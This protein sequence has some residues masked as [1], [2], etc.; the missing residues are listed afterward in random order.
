MISAMRFE[1]FPLGG[2]GGNSVFC[3]KMKNDY[4]FALDPETSFLKKKSK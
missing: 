1:I 4:I 2:G 3:Q